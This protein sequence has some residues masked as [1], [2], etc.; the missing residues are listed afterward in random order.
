V[1]QRHED[2]IMKLTYT[3]LALAFATAA[4]SAFAQSA[5]LEIT[6]KIFPGA[7]SVELG[8]G[9][10]ADLG[11]INARDLLPTSATLLPDVALPMTVSCESE[12]RFAIDAVDNNVGSSAF[13][14][15]F[16]MGLTA[17]DEKIGSAR[18]KLDDSTAD[19]GT[20]YGTTSQNSGETWSPANIGST[21]MT[22]TNILGFSKQTAVTTGPSPITLLQGSLVVSPKIAAANS[23]TID[24]EVPIQGSITLDVKYL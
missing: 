1:A 19:G 8:G 4:P 3:V 6:G 18:L 9:G 2:Q 23:L 13:V 5:D 12:V 22:P 7:C 14:G 20:A 11:A 24:D 21:G 10:I 16:G 17:N 15:E